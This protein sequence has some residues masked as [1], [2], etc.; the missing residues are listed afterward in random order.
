MA[1]R[2]F[3]AIPRNCIP[4]GTGILRAL[5]DTVRFVSVGFLSLGGSLPLH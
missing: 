2:V 1:D 5:V 3:E 4:R